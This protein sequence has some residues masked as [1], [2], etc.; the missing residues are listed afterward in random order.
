MKRAD[1]I[2]EIKNNWRVILPQMTGEAKRRVNGETSYIC[3]LP[4]IKK[5]V[6]AS[7]SIWGYTYI[8][9]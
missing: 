4:V 2:T 6:V 1:A 8:R 9:W 7:I 3:P 5:K